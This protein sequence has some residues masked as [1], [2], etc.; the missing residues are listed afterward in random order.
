MGADF[1][2]LHLPKLPWGRLP[3]NPGCGGGPPKNTP[4]RYN[5]H[6]TSTNRA[7][8]G[9][10]TGAG[11]AES[12]GAGPFARPAAASYTDARVALLGGLGS[13]QYGLYGPRRQE[14]R[15]LSAPVGL[16][17]EDILSLLCRFQNS[18]KLWV[19][20]QQLVVQKRGYLSKAVLR[21]LN[22]GYNATMAFPVPQ[23]S[24]TTIPTFIH[25]PWKAIP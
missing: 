15:V 21:A 22:S 10:V 24:T 1:P 9:T 4:P 6:Y 7:P 12:C 18:L 8:S 23:M 11:G 3:K 14:V 19:A 20:F 13:S 5:P 16:G 2:I 17:E 25:I